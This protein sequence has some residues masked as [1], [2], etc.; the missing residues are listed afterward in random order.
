MA[1]VAAKQNR[2]AMRVALGAAVLLTLGACAARGP[3][4]DRPLAAKNVCRG[5]PIP[6]G[7]IRTNDFWSKKGCGSPADSR[8]DNWMTIT[9]YAAARIG[10]SFTA[11]AGD[12]PEGWSVTATYWDKGRCGQ[13]SKR[14]TE[15]VM[16]LKRER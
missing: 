14:T 13:P 6:G 1:V 5:E 10:R 11:C 16:L 9:D 3:A 7:W 8:V 15:N 12:V 4:P 2:A